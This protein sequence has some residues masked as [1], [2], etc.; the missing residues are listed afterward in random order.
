MS[1]KLTNPG[2]KKLALVSG[3]AHPEL[4]EQISENLG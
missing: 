3:R 2:E 4:A 1:S